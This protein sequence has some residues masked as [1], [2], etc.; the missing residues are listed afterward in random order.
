MNVCVELKNAHHPNLKHGIEVQ[1]PLY[2]KDI[3]NKEGIF[4]VLWYKSDE[5][6]NPTNFNVIKDIEDFLL[7]N[8]SKKYRIKPL[9][10]DCTKKIS[11][12]KTAANKRLK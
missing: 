7:N 1:L 4:L 8:I 3:G 5:F 10:I 2:I 9:I 6:D 12:S 11:P